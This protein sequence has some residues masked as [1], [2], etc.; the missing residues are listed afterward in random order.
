MENM[1]NA[2][3]YLQQYNNEK[4]IRIQVEKD[5]EDTKTALREM[6]EKYQTTIKIYDSLLTQK[7][8]NTPL[9]NTAN[10]EAMDKAVEILKRPTPEPPKEEPKLEPRT[11]GF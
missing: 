1:E 2:E 10:G 7:G 6:V 3:F 5:L 9:L 8:N 11:E 4:A